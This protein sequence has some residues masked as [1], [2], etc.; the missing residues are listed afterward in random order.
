VNTADDVRVVVG[1]PVIRP[2]E[3]LATPGTIG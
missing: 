2:V 1:L 3:E